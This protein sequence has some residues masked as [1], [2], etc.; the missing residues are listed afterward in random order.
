MADKPH[1][2]ICVPYPNHG[3]V[4]DQTIESLEAL[5]E[6]TEVA[7]TIRLIQGGTISTQRNAGVNDQ[8]SQCIHQKVDFDYYLS[9]D[10]DIKFEVPQ[11]LQLINH[12]LDIVGGAYQCRGTDDKAVCGYF[13]AGT[14]RVSKE[15]MRVLDITRGIVEV[16]WIGSGF[17]LIKKEVFEKME[18]PWYRDMVIPYLNEKNEPCNT[19]V[20]ED[21]GFCI[22]AKQ[23]GFKV[24]CDMSCQVVHILETKVATVN[25]IETTIYNNS[26]SV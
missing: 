25:G 9:L 22:G 5:S 26:D 6:C 19:W 10:A 20:G 16:D 11:L 12:N 8:S 23:A 15:K 13:H 3:T 18:Y 1:V 14:Q 17:T 4:S 24:H 21:V 7:T 2:K